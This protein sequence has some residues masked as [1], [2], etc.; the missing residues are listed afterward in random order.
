MG[1]AY[2]RAALLTAALLAQAPEAG[3]A[4]AG[5]AEAAGAEAPGQ[6]S[7]LQE[8]LRQ[9]PDEPALYGDWRMFEFV[10]LAALRAATGVEAATRLAA[11]PEGA[12]AQRAAVE[13]LLARIVTGRRMAYATRD[14]PAA[15]NDFLGVDFLQL[16]WFFQSA[17]AGVPFN[18]L[19][20]DALPR[21][22][23]LGGLARA[24]LAPVGRGGTTVW[25]GAGKGL[26]FWPDLGKS[27]CLFRAERALVGAPACEAL[28]PAL[29]V[30]RDGAASLAELPRYRLLAEALADPALSAGP[31]LQAV[32]VDEVF[33]QRRLSRPRGGEGLPPF[34][35]FAFAER[36]DASGHQLVVA[37][38][39]EE[40]PAA[41]EAAASLAAAL[42]SHRGLKLLQR[43]PALAIQA[44]VLE[45]DD[46]A[47]AVVRL[48][49]PPGIPEGGGVARHG[50][51]LFEYLYVAVLLRFTSDFLTVRD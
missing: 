22:D 27:P 40:R 20:G 46:G 31:V 44:S 32:I 29:A 50:S 13:A 41:A 43:F 16:G 26:P 1:T 35:L 7:P 14:E 11:L 49:L 4:E 24:G 36:Q 33:G 28:D 34:G 45:S 3:G 12:P 19:G 51:F 25:S 9:T 21:G 10:D 2:L 8:M 37:L 47:A 18:L 23:A 30:E 48:A 5:G 42:A 17:F 39:Y 15:W 38:T 6:P